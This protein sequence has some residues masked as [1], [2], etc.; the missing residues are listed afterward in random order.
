ME[1]L[2]I[3]DKPTKDYIKSYITRNYKYLSLSYPEIDN[4][5]TGS[6]YN[7]YFDSLNSQIG[8]YHTVNYLFI[9]T[10]FIGDIP[11]NVKNFVN[12]EILEIEGSRFWNLTMKNVPPSVKKIYLID[13]TNLQP[14]CLQ[15][16][17]K[18]IN[19]QEL[20]ID[21][22]SIELFNISIDPNQRTYD[23]DR[24]ITDII[25]LPDL[26]SLQT[27]YFYIDDIQEYEL[28]ED[29]ETQ[30]RHHPIFKNINHRIN[31]TPIWNSLGHDLIMC[32]RLI[33]DS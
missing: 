31:L 28:K 19:I 17:D 14:G 10:D 25:P 5:F 33:S 24:Q 7:K 32:I 27:I 3:V 26:S 11:T 20:H 16:M 29:W 21:Y 6:G 8:S 12:L 15:E 4:D 13:Q 18:L 22:K 30:L 23:E 1:I 2:T 9:C